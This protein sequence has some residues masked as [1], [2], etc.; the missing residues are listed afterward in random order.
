VLVNNQNSICHKR[1]FLT[2]VIA[3]VD[4]PFSGVIGV[5]RSRNYGHS[6]QIYPQLWNC[7]DTI[8]KLGWLTL[9]QWGIKVSIIIRLSHLV[10]PTSLLLQ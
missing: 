9:N 4:F 6:R 2:S 5:T 8:D 3:R 10:S 7:K 1:N